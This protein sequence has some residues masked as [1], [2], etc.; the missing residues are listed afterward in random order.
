MAWRDDTLGSTLPGYD[1]NSDHVQVRVDL[2][3]ELEEIYGLGG[4]VVRLKQ[5]C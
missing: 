3:D 5:A 1:D 2:W 4:E